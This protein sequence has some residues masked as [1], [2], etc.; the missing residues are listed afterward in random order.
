MQLLDEALAY[1]QCVVSVMGDHAGESV[2]AI[3]KRKI[4]DIGR[5]RRTF[6]LMKSPKARPAQ[7]Q[8]ICRPVP[9]FTIFV[10]PATKGGARPTK[11]ETAAREYSADGQSWHPLP[12]GIGPVTGKLDAG[13]FALVFDKMEIVPSGTLDLWGYADLSDPQK[14][15]KF[16][17]GC[18][19]LCAVRKDMTSHFERIKSR[20]RGVVAVAR[21]ADPYCVWLR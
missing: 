20:Y 21:L 14:P 8:G 7:V 3:F 9:A 4:A 5:T 6:W 19:T 2:D 16:I 11:T 10:R 18:S 13:A 12:Q 17:I 15:L 1:P